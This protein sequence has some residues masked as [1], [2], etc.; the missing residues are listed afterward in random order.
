[1]VT[2]TSFAQTRAA[3]V[4]SQLRT[5]DVSDARVIAAMAAVPREAF[6]PADKVA[7]AYTDRPVRL[8][9]GRALNPPLAVGRL[10]T[11]AGVQPGNKV[12]LIGA[13]TGYTAAV[14]AE[15]GAIVT[16]VEEDAALPSPGMDGF[17]IAPLTVGAPEGG[18]YDVILIDGAVDEIPAALIDQLAEGGR[19]ATGVVDR[20]VTRL[21]VGRKAGGY[22]GLA[23]LADLEMV[24]LPGFAQPAGF[25]F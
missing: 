3:M 19:L 6:V 2:E 13:A 18:P 25:V 20:G 15:I 11:E 21:C 9:G 1:M 14:L 8:A 22:F 12:L 17:V 23:R 24:V 4:E 5:S 7:M 10:L 16:A